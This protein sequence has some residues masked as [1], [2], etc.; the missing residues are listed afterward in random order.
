[1]LEHEEHSPS[2]IGER[3]H[4][5]LTR[6]RAKKLQEQMNS[7]LIDFDINISKDEILPKCSTLMLLRCTHEEVEDTDDQDQDQ[8]F[9]HLLRND[10]KWTH[11]IKRTK[12]FHHRTNMIKTDQSDKNRRSAVFPG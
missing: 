3:N 2:N 5:S 7:F 4:G 8:C 1:M 11:V 9:H 6:S 12:F 10:K